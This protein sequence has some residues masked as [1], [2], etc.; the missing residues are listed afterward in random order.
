MLSINILGPLNTR[1]EIYYHV[2]PLKNKIVKISSLFF[3]YR[4]K[5]FILMSKIEVLS[6]FHWKKIIINNK[7][8]L[9]FIYFY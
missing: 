2:K 1:T 6:D 8:T 7:R 4:E 9:T 5:K 3:C